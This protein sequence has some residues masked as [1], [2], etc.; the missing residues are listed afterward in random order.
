MTEVQIKIIEATQIEFAKNGFVG[1]PVRNSTSAADAN[2]AAI[3]DH[4]GSKEDLFSERVH[5]RL[6]P[7]NNLRPITCSKTGAMIQR[8]RLDF[9]AQGN[10]DLNKIEGLIDNLITFVAGGIRSIKGE[11][12]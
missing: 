3:N 4:F 1:A 8:K 12:K 10:V 9:T 6:G 7:T 2:V 5:Y 11:N